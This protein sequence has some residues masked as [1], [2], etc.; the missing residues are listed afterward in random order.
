MAGLIALLLLGGALTL[1]GAVVLVVH[2]LTHPPRRTYG[3]A[4]G[5][6]LACDPSELDPPRDF[7]AWSFSSHGLDMPVW[8]VAGDEPDGPVVVMVHG[9]G[10]S[11]IGGLVRL[12]AVAPVASRVILWDLPGHGEA[13]GSCAL[14][15]REVEDL[16]ALVEVL[17]CE[18]P[19]VLFGWS[20]GAGIAIACAADTTNPDRAP[21][22]RGIAGVI[23]EAP[24]R[25]AQTPAHRVMHL[26]RLPHRLNL[27]P[28][29]W[30]I[31][32]WVGVGPAWRGFD[33][34]AH[35]KHLRC[36]LLII[37]G[38]HDEVCP[39]DDARAIAAAADPGLVQ[40]HITAG[41]GHNDLWTEPNCALEHTKAVRWFIRQRVGGASVAGVDALP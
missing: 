7:Q 24:Y 22:S 41:A 5:R 34:A 25:L 18:T 23:A 35:A 8:D 21:I 27:P 38:S 29:L 30:L 15:T 13:P 14:G 32:A 17:G 39:I 36:P 11:R 16:A 4:V 9:W 12:G 3:S 20:M 10:D 40:L 2:A 33:R 1:V 28:A 26:R 6:G 31:G 37:H 19:I